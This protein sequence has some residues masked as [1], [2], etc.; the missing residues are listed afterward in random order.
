MT[1]EIGILFG[2]I[3]C[4]IAV[5][6]FYIGRQSSAKISG[7]RDGAL[8]IKMEYMKTSLDEIKTELKDVN[9]QAMKNSIEELKQAVSKHSESISRAHQRIDNITK[10]I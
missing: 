2:L 9:L 5:A 1:I 3:A 8:D 10:V 4:I 7:I 6:T